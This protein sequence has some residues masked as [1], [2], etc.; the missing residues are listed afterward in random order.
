MRIVFGDNAPV[1]QAYD[2]LRGASWGIPAA[3]A[4]SGRP[5]PAPGFTSNCP[6]R[7]GFRKLFRREEEIPSSYLSREREREKERYAT[8]LDS[9]TLSR[10]PHEYRNDEWWIFFFRSFLPWRGWKGGKYES[11]KGKDVE[12]ER[13][14]RI[15]DG[16]ESKDVKGNGK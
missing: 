14:E 16:D 2:R 12:K 3:V 6:R 7:R 5:W 9:I 13:R 8:K 1:N 10:P 11:G 15:E 4:C